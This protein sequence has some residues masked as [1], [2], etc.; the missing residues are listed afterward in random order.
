MSGPEWINQTGPA[1]VRVWRCQE[2]R[3]QG[4]EF[5]VIMH[6][7]TGICVFESP[8]THKPVILQEDDY[9]EIKSS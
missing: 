4:M 2:P 8:I 1:R 6:R 5:D 3:L 9:L 7:I